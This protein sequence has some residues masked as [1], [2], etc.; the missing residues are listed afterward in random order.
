MS[1]GCIQQL[2]GQISRG[3]AHPTSFARW[4]PVGVQALALY[5]RRAE[6]EAEVP[7]LPQDSFHGLRRKWVSER[8][9]L[10]DV[11]V[12]KAGGWRSVATMKRSYQL[13]D[14][15][16]VLEAILEPRRLRESKSS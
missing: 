9:H 3:S 1:G 10:P 13:A 6:R 11:D 7:R 12:A 8:K 2:S 16:G 5:L 4:P 15:A 14:D